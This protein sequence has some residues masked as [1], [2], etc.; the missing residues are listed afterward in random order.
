MFSLN[1]PNYVSRV[2]VVHGWTWPFAG[3][4]CADQRYRKRDRGT[5]IVCFPI[6]QHVLLLQVTPDVFLLAECFFVGLA[7]TRYRTEARALH[8]DERPGSTRSTAGVTA[9]LGKRGRLLA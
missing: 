6:K 3:I 9:Q 1:T 5:C 2:Q 4:D 8:A 7:W